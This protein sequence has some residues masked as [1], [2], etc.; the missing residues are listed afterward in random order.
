M[1]K[2]NTNTCGLICVPLKRA[3]DIDVSKPLGSVI[4]SNY[5]TSVN[6]KARIALNSQF[7]HFTSVA[8]IIN[9][10]FQM[11]LRKALNFSQIINLKFCLVTYLWA[12]N[13]DLLTIWPGSTR[14]A[15]ETEAG[16]HQGRQRRG[17]GHRH[18]KVPRSGTMLFRL[19][20]SL[21]IEVLISSMID[22]VT[23]ITLNFSGNQIKSEMFNIRK[24]LPDNLARA[25][26]PRGRG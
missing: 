8:H 3:A 22:T 9:F 6:F 19:F 21:C 17:G 13:W 1:S 4:K 12:F 20:N 2:N 14:R 26:N 16:G 5:S 11:A 25:E 18:R 7:L 10:G 15:P 24:I 23:L